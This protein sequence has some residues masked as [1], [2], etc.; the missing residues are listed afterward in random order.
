MDAD[1]CKRCNGTGK[2]KYTH[3]QGGKCF[4]CEGTGLAPQFDNWRT[5][6][7]RPPRVPAT[8]LA[9][10]V[11][12]DAA[13]WRELAAMEPAALLSWCRTYRPWMRDAETRA[14]VAKVRNRTAD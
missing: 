9:K 13:W 11:A 5:W 4:A 12:D 8:E 2:T 1:K 3:V 10:R 7:R 14:F 6:Y